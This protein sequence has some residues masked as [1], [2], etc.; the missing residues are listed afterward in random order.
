MGETDSTS[1]GE[2]DAQDRATEERTKKKKKPGSFSKPVRAWN[3]W[4][5][6]NWSLLQDAKRFRAD[7]DDYEA[8]ASELDQTDSANLRREVES[9]RRSL[10]FAAEAI[11]SHGDVPSFYLGYFE[12]LRKEVRIKNFFPNFT[13]KQDGS[14]WFTKEAKQVQANAEMLGPETQAEVQTILSTDPETETVDADRLILAMRNLHGEVINDLIRER[15]ARKRRNFFGI[16]AVVSTALLAVLFFPDYIP[17]VKDTAMAQTPLVDG[18]L[19]APP[20]AGAEGAEGAATGGESATAEDPLLDDRFF[21]IP[22]IVFGLLGAS[23]SGLQ[24]AT[25]LY[26]GSE[27]D[28]GPIEG[29]VSRLITGGVAALFVFLTIRS[30]FVDFGTLFNFHSALVIAF[31][32][33]FSERVFLGTLEKVTGR[34]GDAPQT[35]ETQRE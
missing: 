5:G 23:M 8:R 34:F 25:K 28:G 1:R 35:T 21:Y 32:T 29:T 12:A 16:A 7:L 26:H 18:S 13:R 24:Q 14:N 4:R 15:T 20:T 2:R 19:Q 30:G 6:D 27:D 22:V 9:A 10:D 31:V 17:F 3:T 11:Q 33:G